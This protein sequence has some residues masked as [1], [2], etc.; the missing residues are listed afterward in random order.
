MEPAN[1]T[2]RDSRVSDGETRQR[3]L[4]ASADQGMARKVQY[5][6]SCADRRANPP[7]LSTDDNK[8]CYDQG[9]CTLLLVSDGIGLK[10]T[11]AL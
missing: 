3:T 6:T 11:W 8:I 5:R 1:P 9:R 10:N 4:L 7:S 2:C